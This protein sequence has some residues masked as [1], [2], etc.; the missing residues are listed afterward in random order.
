MEARRCYSQYWCWGRGKKENGSNFWS[1]LRHC[2]SRRPSGAFTGNLKTFTTLLPAQYQ[3]LLY[4]TPQ[5][6][7]TLSSVTAACIPVRCYFAPM[8]PLRVAD[9]WTIRRQCQFSAAGPAMSCPAGYGLR[10][11]PEPGLSASLYTDPG[12]PACPPSCV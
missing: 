11:K 12:H 4:C 10:Q 8:A 6:R 7:D 9:P 5:L 1:C 2:K 3:A